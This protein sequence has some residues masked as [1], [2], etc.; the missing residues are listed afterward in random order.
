MAVYERLAI[1]LSEMRVLLGGLPDPSEAEFI[2]R[3]IWHREVHHS[4]ALE[5]NTLLLDQVEALLDDGRAV[6]DADLAEFLEVRGYANAARWVYAQAVT[7]VD[8][9]DTLP[10]SITDI[11]N[12]HELALGPVWGVA[13]PP[14]ATPE[15]GPG[16]FRRHNIP[17]FPGGMTPPSW[18]D[19]PAAL[20]DWVG[21]LRELNEASVLIEG[22]AETHARFEQIHPFLDGNGRTGRLILNLLLVRAGYPPAIILK[23]DRDKYRAALRRADGG[24]PGALAEMLARAVTENIQKFILPAKAQPDQPVPLASLV[25]D[26]LGAPALRAAIERG[27]LQALRGEDGHYRSTATWVD[28]YLAQRYRRIATHTTE[29]QHEQT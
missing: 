17:S 9:K 29:P 11:R 19:V 12:V 4:T 23:R 25:R 21:S 7:P 2:W 15:E 18:V 22:L 16:S 13:P 26:G 20:G 1:S 24:D 6:G 27:R 5:G 10:V 8:W 14:N 28:E 3:R